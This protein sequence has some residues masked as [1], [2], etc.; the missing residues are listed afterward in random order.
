[1]S[2]DNVEFTQ[3][4]PATPIA[5]PTP[6]PSDTGAPSPTPT[7]ATPAV[8]TQPGA[9]PGGTEATVPS[10]RLREAREAYERRL[11]SE[12]EREKSTW[13]K[14]REAYERKIQALAGVLPQEETRADQIKEQFFTL[15][16][17]Y[18]NLTPEKLAAIDKL[19]ERSTVLESENELRWQAHSTQRLNELYGLATQAGLPDNDQVRGM[20]HTAL[21]GYL[22]AN[23]HEQNRFA[24]DPNFIPE[25]FKAYSAAMIDPLRRSTVAAVQN[26]VAPALPQDTPSGAVRTATPVPAPK[27][28]DERVARSWTA[29]NQSKNGSGI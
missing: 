12:I 6:V 13:L 23:P 7:P 2:F 3:T 21:I 4:A 26:R 22:S 20:L 1:M 28:I 11:A 19:I 5:D 14:E 15:F 17:Q 24:A 18:R 27:D 29:F 16:P 25:F 9:T 10:W 8:G